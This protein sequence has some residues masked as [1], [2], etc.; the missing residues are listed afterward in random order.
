MDFVFAQGVPSLP[1][2][3]AAR[4]SAGDEIDTLVQTGRRVSSESWAAS[5]RASSG[6]S[7]SRRAE[8]TAVLKKGMNSF[9][10]CW[11]PGRSS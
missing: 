10:A 7:V 3:L 4:V 5:T 8:A 9:C 6:R 2:V 11:E 1:G